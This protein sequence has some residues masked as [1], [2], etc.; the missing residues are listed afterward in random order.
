MRRFHDLF[1]VG[2]PIIAMAHVPPLPDTSDLEVDGYTWNPV[3]PGRVK[4]FVD[5]APS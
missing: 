5:A 2:K 3:D 4:W 1:P